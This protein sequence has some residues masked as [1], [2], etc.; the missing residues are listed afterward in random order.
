MSF[1]LKNAIGHLRVS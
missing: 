1:D